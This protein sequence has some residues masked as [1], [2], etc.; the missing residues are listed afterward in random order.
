M[1]TFGLVMTLG[2]LFMSGFLLSLVIRQ[3]SKAEGVIIGLVIFLLVTSI[4]LLREAK[5]KW[6]L[7]LIDNEGIT[8]K[9][10][11]GLWLSRRVKMDEITGIKRAIEHSRTSK[12]ET[13][14]VY[15]NGYREIEI[16]DTYYKNFSTI[17]GELAKRTKKLGKEQYSFLKH[18]LNSFGFPIKLK[19]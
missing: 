8:I 19:D 11:L 9:P 13:I 2:F 17:N 5:F 15:V 14:Y 10:F 6:N 1:M 16:S 7:I 3:P 4:V 18:L 12:G